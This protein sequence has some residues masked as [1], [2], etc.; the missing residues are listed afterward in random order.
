MNESLLFVGISGAVAIMA[1]L[2]TGWF[3]YTAS[4]SYKETE[5]LRA[6]LNR[7]LKDMAAYQRLE[8]RYISAL[9][10]DEKPAESWK[11]HIRKAMRGDGEASPSEEFH[12]FQKM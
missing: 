4:T 11:R 12:S 7:A 10:T 6:Q 8:E 9:A 2:I 1:S 3:T 5:R